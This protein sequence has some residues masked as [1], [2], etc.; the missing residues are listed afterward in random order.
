MVCGSSPAETQVTSPSVE[1]THIQKDGYFCM[2][3]E[4]LEHK[5]HQ[6]STND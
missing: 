6:D 1:R 3:M 2:A 4:L 5:R